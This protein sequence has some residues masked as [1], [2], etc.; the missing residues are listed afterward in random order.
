MFKKTWHPQ[1]V[2]H[3]IKA[4][5]G[6]EALNSYYY[7]THYPDVYAAAEREFGSWKEAIEACGID[8]NTIRKY[9]SWTRQSVI[10]EIR[11]S[12]ENGESI[13]S[14]YA[15]DNKKPL[16]MAAIK[17]FR[18]WGHAVRLAGIDYDQVRLRRSMTKAQIKR[19][20]LELFRQRVDLSY[21]NMRQN[22]QYLLAA[23]MK[24]LGN[25]SWAEARRHCGILA[26]FRLRQEKRGEQSR[27]L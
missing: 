25:G 9:R 2:V 4:R 13:N 24:K 15:Q 3:H 6:K 27:M 20:I 1:M 7:A 23:G 12:A 22:Y 17:R 18:S 21:T 10:H 26:N 14:Q 19:E 11:K 8:Y 5:V 16:Y